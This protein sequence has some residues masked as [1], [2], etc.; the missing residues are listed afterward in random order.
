MKNYGVLFLAIIVVLSLNVGCS[1]SVE[2]TETET[3]TNPNNAITVYLDEVFAIAF[4]TGRTPSDLRW[5]TEYNAN[6]LEL[7]DSMVKE[8]YFL[9]YNPDV[10]GVHV[11]IFRALTISDTSVYMT[12]ERTLPDQPPEVLDEKVIVIHIK[13][14]P[15]TL[16]EVE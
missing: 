11:F 12:H 2:V 3:F 16:T 9:E 15:I 6:S 4:D 13:Q 7:V 5:R 1:E 8:E 14:L 10:G